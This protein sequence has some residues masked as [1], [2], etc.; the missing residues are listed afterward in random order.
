MMLPTERPPAPIRHG[1]ARSFAQVLAETVIGE[2]GAIAWNR[3]PAQAFSVP[4]SAVEDASLADGSRIAVWPDAGAWVAACARP[5]T[6]DVAVV[7]MF[8]RPSVADA[9]AAVMLAETIAGG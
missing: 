2:A 1:H 7:A 4:A 9:F 5:G 3:V 6:A 8:E